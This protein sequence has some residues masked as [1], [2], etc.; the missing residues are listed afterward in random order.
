MIGEIV[1]VDGYERSELDTFY[2]LTISC[3]F[4]DFDICRF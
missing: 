2:I 1:L 3:G 4:V